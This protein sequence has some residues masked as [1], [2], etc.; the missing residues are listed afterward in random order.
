LFEGVHPDDYVA[1][2]IQLNV[3]YAVNEKFATLGTNRFASELGNPV[4]NINYTHGLKTFNPGS[5][6]YNKWIASMQLNAYHGRIGEASIFLEGG[7]ID[8][9]LPYGL[10]FTGEGSKNDLF[11]FYSQ[12]AF[13]TMHPYEFLSDR[14]VNLFFMHDF[15]SLLF[16]TKRLRPEFKVAYNAGWGNI[17]K[18]DQYNFPFASKDKL[19]QEAGLFIDNIVRIKFTFFYLKLGLGAYYRLGYYQYDKP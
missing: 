12:R 14:Y 13:Q 2:N 11:S 5:F 17:E 16:K 18:T 7:Y 19:Y 10:M 9:P 3:R 15:G 6:I 1:D 4:F 8:R